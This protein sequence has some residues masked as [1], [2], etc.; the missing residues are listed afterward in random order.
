[1][2]TLSA[3]Q[4]TKKYYEK[5]LYQI[6]QDLEGQIS[7]DQK[8][9]FGIETLKI[10]PYGLS[11]NPFTSF[12]VT[13]YAKKNYL[14][15]LRKSCLSNLTINRYFIEVMKKGVSRQIKKDSGM[16]FRKI[17]IQDLIITDNSKDMSDER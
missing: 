17:R 10:Y 11:L 4:E 7:Y 9:I 2:E 14:K 1:M 15:K 3:Q 13:S 6:E 16:L 12:N 8:Q 5:E